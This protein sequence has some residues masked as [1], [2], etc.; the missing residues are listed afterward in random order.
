MKSITTGRWEMGKAYRM[1]RRHKQVH[2]MAD[3][4][5]AHYNKLW[6]TNIL[7]PCVEIWWLKRNDSGSKYSFQERNKMIKS[8]HFLVPERIKIG[9]LS[10]KRKKTQF[11][12]KARQG[13][14]S[15]RSSIH[16]KVR[17][18]QL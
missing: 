13:R 8:L 17:I 10:K 14:A 7:I 15:P 12:Y 11:K 4:I 3:S 5:F 6:S 16:K 9:R 18:R 1:Q 2:K